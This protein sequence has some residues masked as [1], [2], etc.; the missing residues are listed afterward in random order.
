MMNT[1]P[2]LTRK[3]PVPAS[4]YQLHPQRWLRDLALDWSIIVA[5][6]WLFAE[7][8]KPWYLVPLFALIIGGRIHALG[9]LAHDGTHRLA[10][11]NQR[12]NDWMT[13][14]FVAWPLFVAVDHGYRPWHF[15]HHK[16]LGT[17]A[18]PELLSYRAEEPYPGPVSWAKIRRYLIT[19]LLGLGI[20]DLFKFIRAVFPFKKP[21]RFLGPLLLW[22]TFLGVTILLGLQWVF[23][24]WVWSVLTGFWAVFRVRTWTEHIDV[25]P[26]GKE[27]SHRFRVGPL[28]RFFFFPHNTFCHYEHH[29]WPQVPYYHLPKVRELDQSRPVLWLSEVFPGDVGERDGERVGEVRA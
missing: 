2:L 4:L 10:F 26:A 22:L 16:L 3:P 21:S 11:K 14:I 5:A 27:S 15:A 28:A 9:L 1:I 18:D 6:F 17:D 19:D 8:D 20:I 7:L 25:E 24:L 13:E 23:F 29:K 12:L